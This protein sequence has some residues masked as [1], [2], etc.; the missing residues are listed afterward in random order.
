MSY[1]PTAPSTSAFAMQAAISF[2]IAS[3]AVLVGVVYL[4]VNA[5]MRAFLALGILYVI[6]STFTL[7]KVVR[8][9]HEATRVV[10]RIDEVRLE[11][12]IADHDPFG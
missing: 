8:D 11:R 10:S 12:F 7:A 5:W 4:P 6:T 3:G 9:R 1:E 2:A